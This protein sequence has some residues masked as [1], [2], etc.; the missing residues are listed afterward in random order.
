VVGITNSYNNIASSTA[1]QKTISD[2]SATVASTPGCE[3]FFA[4]F[5]SQGK[6]KFG[7]YFG[8]KGTEFLW[9]I[10]VD[11]NGAIYIGGDTKSK[12]A[13]LATSGAFQV[14]PGLNGSGLLARFDSIGQR[15]WSTFYSSG[16]AYIYDIKA[17][18]DTTLLI[19]GGTPS[20]PN[21][22]TIGAIQPKSMGGFDCFVANFT[23]KGTRSWGTYFGSA[24]DDGGSGIT[25]D[26]TG[27]IYVAGGTS[28]KSGIATPDAHQK[29]SHGSKISENFLVKL[30]LKNCSDE[31]HDLRIDGDTV[32]CNDTL[33]LL[34]LKGDKGSRYFWQLPGSKIERDLVDTITWNSDST[35]PSAVKLLRVD[36]AGNLDS[37]ST[38]IV[39]YDSLSKI[40]WRATYKGNLKYVLEASDTTYAGYDWIL[41]DSL[42]L[43]GKSVQWTFSKDGAHFI[44]LIA[45]SGEGCT[46]IF[47]S[48]LVIDLSG[49]DETKNE[50]SI[51]ISPNPTRGDVFVQINSPAKDVTGLQVFDATGRIVYRTTK[52]VVPG[53]NVIPIP[54]SQLQLQQGFYICLLKTANGEFREKIF[55]QR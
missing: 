32:S 27:K 46:A 5:N 35:K 24:G 20:M 28:S 49:V 8:G 4:R 9:A 19:T 25:V 12:D 39:Y 11:A 47:D 51:S 10:A 2:D 7:S 26:R 18:P 21:I 33:S 29:E 40:K 34:R 38:N 14:A 36:A 22:A 43:S 48:V 1:F 53:R 15:T 42:K 41:D 44:K 6:R 52:Q 37:I 54:L 23:P 3:G 13:N 50:N 31:S 17:A 45:K 55:Y 30:C 16:S